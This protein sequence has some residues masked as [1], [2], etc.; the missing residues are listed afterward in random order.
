MCIRD[1]YTACLNE[2]LD[3]DGRPLRLMYLEMVENIDVLR[4][5]NRNFILWEGFTLSLIHI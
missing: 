1:R 5:Q 4:E 2:S 3:P